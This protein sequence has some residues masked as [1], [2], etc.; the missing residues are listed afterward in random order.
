MPSGFAIALTSILIAGACRSDPT[1]TRPATVTHARLE[2]T[3]A[4]EATEP[5]GAGACVGR[6]CYAAK[7]G[8]RNAIGTALRSC[9]SRSTTGFYRDGFCSTG[10]D[11]TGVHVVCATV[12]DAFLRFSAAHGNDLITPRGEFPGLRDG[13]A[14]CLC[15]ARFREALDAVIAPPFVMEATD[16]AALRMMTVGELGASPVELC[17]APR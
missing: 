17:R 3:G 4:I 9:P 14:W 2:A 1:T 8:M 13:D 12:T 11:D 16:E 10:A 5:T 6:V 15:A 7:P